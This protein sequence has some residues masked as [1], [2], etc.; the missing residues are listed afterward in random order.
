MRVEFSDIEVTRR[1]LA[2][3]LVSVFVF[4]LV[5]MGA[6][7][8][9]SA[10]NV[11]PI[12]NSIQGLNGEPVVTESQVQQGK[13]IFQSEGMMNSGSILG[14]GA[15]FGVDYTANTLDLKVQYMR[16]YYARQR[17]NTEYENLAEPEQAAVNRI[18]ESELD[19]STLQ[20]QPQYSAASSSVILCLRRQSIGRYIVFS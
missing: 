19:S 8:W 12:P 11:P 6:G 2:K 7:A 5:V 9:Y 1:T 14:N 17:Y 13:T 10:Q 15:Y 4:N 18:V 16:Q 3:I 20:E